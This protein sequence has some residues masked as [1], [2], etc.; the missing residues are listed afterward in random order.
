MTARHG[1][2]SAA[3]P[4]LV[5]RTY[6]GSTTGALSAAGRAARTHGQVISAPDTG[7][8]GDLHRDVAGP[9]SEQVEQSAVAVY[10]LYPTVQQ[11][12]T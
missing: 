8:H 9:R 6:A 11:V 7:H 2:G 12:A 3:C 4:G 5:T 10:G 1:S